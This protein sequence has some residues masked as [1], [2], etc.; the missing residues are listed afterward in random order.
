[1]YMWSTCVF[2]NIHIRYHRNR[3]TCYIFI[4]VVHIFPYPDTESWCPSSY[5]KRQASLFITHILFSWGVFWGWS[6]ACLLIRNCAKLFWIIISPSKSFM[7]RYIFLQKYLYPP[8]LSFSWKMCVSTEMQNV[9]LKFIIVQ[10]QWK[11]ADQMHVFS[12][13]ES[14]T[15]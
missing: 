9:S 1:M 4:N 15:V 13:S 14:K 3:A 12:M 11:Q 6:I 8:K 7:E 10:I 5:D 2:T